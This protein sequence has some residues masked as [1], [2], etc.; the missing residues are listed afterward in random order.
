MFTSTIEASIDDLRWPACCCRCGSERY[1]VRQHIESVVTWTV[2]AVTTYRRIGVPVPVCT[3][4]FHRRTS[5]YAGAAVFAAALIGAGSAWADR[6]YASYF[7]GALGLSIVYMLWRGLDAQPVRLLGLAE[8]T[9]SLTFRVY[10]PRTADALLASPTAR[11]GTWKAVRRPF[12]HALV[13]VWLLAMAV[14]AI[15]RFLH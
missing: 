14:A 5:W 9:R 1:R 2:I 13:G 15:S 11:P 4:C 6:P 10:L 7:F 8:K 12:V 3:R